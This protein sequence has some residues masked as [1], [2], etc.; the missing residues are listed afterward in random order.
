MKQSFP[1]AITRSRHPRKTIPE[2]E[3][4]RQLQ[5]DDDHPSLVNITTVY[6]TLPLYASQPRSFTVAMQMAA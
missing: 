3:F 6:L 2:A 1:W 5:L 4:L